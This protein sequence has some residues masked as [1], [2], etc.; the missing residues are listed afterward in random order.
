MFLIGAETWGEN[1]G[2]LELTLF[3]VR[4]GGHHWRSISFFVEA[5]S[6]HEFEL[7]LQVSDCAPDCFAGWQ[8]KKESPMGWIWMDSDAI[9]EDDIDWMSDEDRTLVAALM[10]NK[11][12]CVVALS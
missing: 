5:F 2:I 7:V 10:A 12:Q 6:D 3:D 1:E 9:A 8:Y 11:S 4:F